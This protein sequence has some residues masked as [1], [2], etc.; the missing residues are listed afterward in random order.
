LPLGLADAV[1]VLV[2]GVDVVDMLVVLVVFVSDFVAEAGDGFTMVVF[3]SVFPPAGEAPAAGV[4]S[5]RCSQAAKSA[6]L[7]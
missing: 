5:V 7:S 3:V 6:A 4:T 2:A 1:V